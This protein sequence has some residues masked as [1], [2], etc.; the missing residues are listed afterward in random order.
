MAEL[1]ETVKKE[2]LKIIDMPDQRANDIIV[3]IHQNKGIFPNRRKKNFPE[4][5]D[6]EYSKIEEIYKAIFS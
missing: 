2:I 1:D 3:F 4:I 6:A 5:T